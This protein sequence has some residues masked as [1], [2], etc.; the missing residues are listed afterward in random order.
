[1]ICKRAILTVLGLGLS[2]L[3][4]PAAA[5]GSAAEVTPLG[6]RILVLDLLGES[7]E[8]PLRQTLTGVLTSAV[9]R[10]A[11]V[12][13]VV[14]TE[15]VRTLLGVEAQ[16]QLLGCGEDNCFAEIAGSLGADHIVAGTVGRVGDAFA[17]TLRLL[18]PSKAG[19][20]RSIARETPEGREA[21]LALVRAAGLELIDPA[22]TGARP[23][24]WSVG[25][26][27][28]AVA[29]A[30]RASS[31]VG[32]DAELAFRVKANHP[33]HLELA[34]GIALPGS[35]PLTLRYLARFQPLEVGLLLRATPFTGTAPTISGSLQWALGAGGSLGASWPTPLG[36]VGLRVEVV[37]SQALGL[38]GTLP[39][40]LAL[41]WR[42]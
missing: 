37:Y 23:R 5:A 9:R 40:S 6:G 3:L 14:S 28:G 39:V 32:L 10:A 35:Y 25:F 4:L 1:M 22:R 13:E 21:L 8:A 7:V 12:A 41:V 27:V 2:V 33:A 17:L 34:V 31:G 26:S 20:V 42:L 29:N 15:D 36:K 24:N 16:K 30:L 38:G 19:V 18:D 11:P